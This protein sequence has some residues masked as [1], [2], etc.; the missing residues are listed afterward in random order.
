MSHS[1]PTREKAHIRTLLEDVRMRLVATDG[2][3]RLIHVNR[4]NQRANTLN[5]INERSDDV[6]RILKTESSKMWFK[7]MGRDRREDDDDSPKIRY[8]TPDEEVDEARHTDRFLETPLGPDALQKRLLRLDREAT[9]SEQEQGVNFLYLALGFLTWFESENSRRLREAPL[10]LLPVALT[11]SKQ[12]STYSLN[13]RDEEFAT[14]LSL[15]K[16]LLEE[17]R[18]S[19]PEIE[20]SEDWTPSCYFGQIERSITGRPEWKVDR[21]G[22]QLGFF[23]FGKQLMLRDLDLENWA[24][25]SLLGH[26]LFRNIL[27]SGFSRCDPAFPPDTPLDQ[28]LEP[29]DIVQVIDA[30][31]SQTKVIEEA[32]KGANLVVQG[33]PGTGKSQTITNIIAAAVHD[34]KTVLFMAEKM[35]ALSVVYQRLQS[36]GLSNPCLELHSHKAQKGIL[37]KD[38]KR[39]LL[40]AATPP[41]LPTVD[42]S[43]LKETR[44]RLNRTSNLLHTCVP[45]LDFTPFEVLSEVIGFMGRGTTQPVTPPKGLEQH[46]NTQRAVIHRDLQ[47]LAKA[48]EG[49]GSATEHPFLGVR[50][51]DLQPYELQ[52]LGLSLQDAVQHLDKLSTITPPP[53]RFSD[54][55][56]IK[57]LLTPPPQAAA[58]LPVLFGRSSERRME[59]AVRLGLTWQGAREQATRDFVGGA[60]DEPVA[61]LREPLVR[62]THGIFSWLVR[63]G[64]DYRRAERILRS[65]IT[66]PLPRDPTDRLALL[67][68]LAGLQK[69]RQEFR[70]A[71]WMREEL[72][73]AWLG[74]Q[75]DFVQIQEIQDWLRPIEGTGL[76]ASAG[77]LDELLR[78]LAETAMTPE[79]LEADVGQARQ[80]VQKIVEKLDLDL[81]QIVPG[82][83][84]DTILLAT[85]R[86]WFVR[87]R[88]QAECYTQWAELMRCHDRLQEHGLTAL[89]AAVMDADAGTWTASRMQE[90]YDYACAQARWESIREQIPE[91]KNPRYLERQQWAE[92]FQDLEGA[93][94]RQIREFICCEHLQRVPKGAQGEMG[95]IRGEA[96]KSRRHRSIRQLMSDAGGMLQKIK[97]VFLMSPVSIAKFLPPGKIRFDLLV[98][99]EA[100]QV[101]P[102]DALGAIARA[103]QI[104]VV[105]DQQQLPPTSFFDRLAGDGYEEDEDSPDSTVQAEE[106][107]NILSLC[108]ARGL[109]NRMLEWH[110]RSKDP[111]LIQVSNA[112]F[113]ENRLVLPASPLQLEEYY[114]LKFH[115]VAGV[116]SRGKSGGRTKSTNRIEATELVKSVAE[117][118]RM[119]PDY[120]LGIV[121]FSMA[122]STMISEVLEYERRQDGVLDKFLRTDVNEEVFVKNI[123]N[124]Q[125]DERDVIMISIGY[126]PD[127]PNGGLP[128]MNF[129]PINNEGGE[130]RL[131]V[132]FTRARM[133][134]EVFASFDPEDMDLTRTSKAGPRVLKR[135]LQFSKDGQF[136]SR[137]PTNRGFDSPFERDVSEVIRSFG[138]EADSQVGTDRFRIDIG[139][140]PKERPGQYIL[141]VECDGATYHSSAWARERDRLRQE[142]LENMGWKFHRIWSTDWFHNQ[143]AEKERLKKALDWARDSALD[144]VGVVGTN[145]KNPNAPVGEA[146]TE[147][148]DGLAD[149]PLPDNLLRVPTYEKAK[150]ASINPENDFYATTKDFLTQIVHEVVCAEGP[151]HSDE[152]ARRI[153]DAYGHRSTAKARGIIYKA[154][155]LAKQHE[156]ELR[157]VKDFWFTQAQATEVPIRDRSSESGPTSEIQFVSPME[158][159]AAVALLEKENGWMDREDQI[160][161]V[162]KL[163]GFYRMGSKVR[164]TIQ[165]A[166]ISIPP[167]WPQSAD[168]S[169]AMDEEPS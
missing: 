91:L 116:Y 15:K 17:H 153:L 109:P 159:R 71:S 70:D 80:A 93:R 82:Q 60:L 59:T 97:P 102:E 117:H 136:H 74:E 23:S 147:S 63:M 49:S 72:G 27:H 154:L 123:E 14:N 45:D 121:T 122:Q 92:Q 7:A 68:R 169:P 164:E 36:L 168:P 126:G 28:L 96:N 18:L 139:V 30:D 167:A 146:E 46:S 41:P 26:E 61:S 142:T 155:K 130:R 35:A 129:G 47:S 67:D 44:D 135:F 16:R 138:Y 39:T 75:T 69:T 5:I 100:S 24:E 32:R 103:D 140:R 165:N 114:G 90:D 110:Y 166:L 128:S 86:E 125:G 132:L 50:A 111:S 127:Q 53:K 150:L 48:L 113:Y 31:A 56:A 99:D 12:R 87:M 13:Y 163:L 106:M 104:V 21:D 94:A 11:R 55:Q 108:E 6:F 158:I 89:L 134:C 64:R 161:S 149:Q 143:I 66:A 65:L 141:A 112:E 101:R 95:I 43:T 58:Y 98:I 115:R 157:C 124:V 42:G 2:R 107:E 81:D 77:Q 133:R 120:S 145:G 54:M 76:V 38:L 137:V 8:A 51:I 20:E 25:E 144:G 152:V 162:A 52:A 19:L 105:G 85:L 131:N 73:S 79:T 62:A 88:E 151:I 119:R 40:S 10:L 22:M 118:A 78:K 9:I 148:R 1:D 57:L 33:P 29:H 3:N 83:T 37:F 4:E 34:H 160:R 156:K 84:I